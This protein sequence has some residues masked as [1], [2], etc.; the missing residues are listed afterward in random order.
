MKNSLTESYDILGIS[1]ATLCLIHCVVFP[2][3]TIIPF[4]FADNAFIDCFFAC[5]GIFVVTK[6]LMSRANKKVKY[7]LGIS[8]LAIVLD[9]LFEILFDLN[10]GLIF[11]GGIGMITG[12]YLNYK[13]HT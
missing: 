4:G 11:I 3:L 12:H 2:L 9:L 1:S 5:V 7:I 10:F 6:V 13:S 8:I